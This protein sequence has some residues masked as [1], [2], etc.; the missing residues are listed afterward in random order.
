MNNIFKKKIPLILI[1]DDSSL[2]RSQMKDFIETQGYKCIVASDGYEA[3]ELFRIHKLDIVLLDFVM[4]TIDGADTCSILRDLPGFDECAVFVMTSLTDEISVNKSYEAGA[5]DYITKPINFAVLKQRIKRTIISQQTERELIHNN[6][7]SH[8]IL[9]YAVEG[10]LTLD[11]NLNIKFANPA[12]LKILN[13]NETNII[14]KNVQLLIPNYEI[15]KIPA[16]GNWLY[17]LEAI[18]SDGMSLPIELTV[19]RFFVDEYYYTIIFKDITERKQ[20][21]EKIK[22][23][24]FYDT[25]TDLP[26]RILL[27]ERISYEIQRAN[28]SKGKFALMYLDL[29]RFK[30]VNDT[31]GHDMGDKLLVD[32]AAR[33]KASVREEDFV[34]RMGGDEFVILLTDLENAEHI[35]KIANTILDSIKKPLI[36][37]GNSLSLT[38]S[39]GVTIFPDDG[40]DYEILLTNADIA[41]YRAKEKGKNNFQTFTQELN[42]KAIERLELENS[43]RRAIEYNEFILHYQ[44]KVNTHTSEIIG[45]EAL[46]RWQHPK[47]GLLLPDTFIPLAEETGLIVQIGEWVLRTACQYN[48]SLQS[49]GFPNI[50]VAVNLSLRQFEMQN[51]LEIIKNILDETG[52][53]PQYLELEITESIAMKNVVHTVEVIKELQMIGVKFSID[54]FGTGYSSLS[55]INDLSVNKLKIDKS[56]VN[57]I[58]DIKE[59]SIIASTVLALG[60]N[61]KMQVIAE[62]V[63]TQNQVDFL[64]ENNCDEMQGYFIA[65]PMGPDDFKKMLKRS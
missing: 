56:F 40:T 60:K 61:L 54:D 1:V 12:A 15:K 11:D 57:K 5:T 53:E 30:L 6:A 62:G 14:G 20:Y 33:L 9:N 49:I 18:K 2:A 59:T 63:E 42:A 10:I 21:E 51:L 25:L 19:S 16:T 13:Y 45:S 41:M 47:K 26:N 52:L 65:K 17:E 39:I 43:L 27:R 46:I 35:G 31:L 8:S 24:A 64:R 58:S 48:K 36:I 23:Q 7:F 29:D 4:P 55:H 34:V 38:I 50:T 3:I 32:M 37:D 22:K 28:R 44:P